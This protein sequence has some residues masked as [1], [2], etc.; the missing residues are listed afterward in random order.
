[1]SAEATSAPAT[2]RRWAG[3]SAIATALVFAAGNALWGFEQPDPGASTDELLDFYGDASDRIVAGALLSLLSIAG[4][5]FFA[6]AVRPILAELDRGEMF[7]NV[8]F[9]G[10]LLGAAAGL[11]AETINMVAALRAADGELTDS[12]AQAAFEISYVLGFNAAGVGLGLLSIALGAVALRT[13]ALLPRWLAVVSLVIGVGMLTP[14]SQFL[15]GPSFLILLLVG[16]LLVLD[17]SP[18]IPPRAA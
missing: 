2:Q 13:R 3:T 17:S 15:I 12:L 5:V 7:A 11:G 18:T 10:A 14:L 9:G 1:M 6:S 8:A 4:L 16:V